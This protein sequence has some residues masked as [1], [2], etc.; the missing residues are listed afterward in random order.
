V[1]CQVRWLVFLR[2]K[3]ARKVNRLIDR[4][5]EAVGQKVVVR[6][7]ERYWKDQSLFRVVLTCQLPV[8]ELSSATSAVL[9]MCW[10]LARS[11]TLQAPQVYED[12]RWEFCGS[13]VSQA[14][15]IVGLT[16]IDLEVRSWEE[17]PHDSAS[18]TV[19]P[20]EAGTA[21]R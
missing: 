8:H 4:F 10:G 14:I 7:C 1:S 17:S 6:E 21:A 11:W 15:G 19:A 12:G 2:L 3:S 20:N 9:Q 18:E 5:A 13:A 16:Y